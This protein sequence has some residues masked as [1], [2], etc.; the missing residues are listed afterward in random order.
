MSEC[1]IESPRFD[2][3]YR[4]E[5]S[6]NSS[7]IEQEIKHYSPYGEETVSRSIINLLDSGI[8]QA[9]IELGWTPPK[10]NHNER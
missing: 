1:K 8:R 7:Q 9:L 4:V 3:G 6:Y 2:C 10:E 5:T